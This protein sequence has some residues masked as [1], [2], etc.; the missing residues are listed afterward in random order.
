MN[1]TRTTLSKTTSTK[2]TFRLIVLALVIKQEQQW[3]GR[4]LSPLF[5]GKIV[6]FPLVILWQS[7]VHYSPGDTIIGPSTLEM[8]SLLKLKGHRSI[9]RLILT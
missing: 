9:I 2:Y 7:L 1:T 6:A 3:E 5:N 8:T 4:T